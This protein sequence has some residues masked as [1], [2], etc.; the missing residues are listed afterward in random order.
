MRRSSVAFEVHIPSGLPIV[1]ADG[2][3]LLRLIGNLL[4]NARA[5]TPEGGTVTLAARANADGVTVDVSD[6]GPGIPEDALPHLF[7]RYYRGDDVRTRSRERGTGLGLAIALETA[8]RHGGDL[9]AES[10]PGQGSI[11]RLTL[12]VEG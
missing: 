3:R 1:D 7:S 10:A 6:T 11:F 5:H 9:V 12:P 2:A 4:D 8:R